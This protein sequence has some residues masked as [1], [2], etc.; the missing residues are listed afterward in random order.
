MSLC[1]EHL[2]EKYNLGTSVI[3]FSLL[4]VSEN[5]GKRGDELLEEID[6]RE[7]E[8]F[9]KMMDYDISP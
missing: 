2:D 5:Q 3:T 4:L 6:A 7:D 8:I 9:E 1:E